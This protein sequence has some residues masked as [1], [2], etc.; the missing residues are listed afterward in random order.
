MSPLSRSDIFFFYPVALTAD[1]IDEFVAHIFDRGV[2]TVCPDAVP[3]P[4]SSENP[5]P[6]VRVLFFLNLS[7]INCLILSF[8]PDLYPPHQVDVDLSDSTGEYQKQTVG[9]DVEGHGIPLIEP[10]T[11]NPI[12][13]NMAAPV[14]PPA[15]DQPVSAAPLSSGQKR[16]RIML[17]SK[18]KTTIS[19]D[20]VITELPSYHES[21][22]RLNLFSVNLAFRRL[23]EAFQH[24]S[25]AIRTDATVGADTQPAKKPR[26]SSM[27]RILVPKYVMLLS[28]ILLLVTSV[29]LF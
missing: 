15:V 19:S 24:I 7:Q 29:H 22:N 2:P 16:K 21:R 12:G 10:I 3:L 20:Q 6:L 28:C 17:A 26:A 18:R 9:D 13:S 27:R 11:S 23:F 5:P 14:H 4:F 25:Q 8:K 1:E